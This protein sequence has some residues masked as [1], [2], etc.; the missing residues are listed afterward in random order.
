MN[1][2]YEW[3]FNDVNLQDSVDSALVMIFY[4]FNA[5]LAEF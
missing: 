2:F 3:F 4:A 5:K 1:D